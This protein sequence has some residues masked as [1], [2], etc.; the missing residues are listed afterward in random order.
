MKTG[1]FSV[2]LS[3]SIESIPYRIFHNC[4]SLKA[5]II[6]NSVITIEEYAFESSGLTSGVLLFLIAKASLL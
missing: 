5:V 4:I 1:A 3:N 2:I 6:P